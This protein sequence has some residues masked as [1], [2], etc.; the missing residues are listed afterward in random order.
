MPAERFFHSRAHVC[1]LSSSACISPVFQCAS[2]S[3]LRVAIDQHACPLLFAQ[4]ITRIAKKQEGVET[5]ECDIEKKTVERRL[6]A[7]SVERMF[8]APRTSVQRVH[9]VTQKRRSASCLSVSW[10]VFSRLILDAGAH[11]WQW[12][13]QGQDRGKAI[14]VVKGASLLDGDINY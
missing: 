7:N 8:C 9:H 12:H 3:F 2:P 14:E 11:H 6:L 5:V 4:A 1:V 13:G 10:I